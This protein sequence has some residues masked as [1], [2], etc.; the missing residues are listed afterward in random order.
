MTRPLCYILSAKYCH[1]WNM[2][3]LRDAR[4]AVTLPCI[5]LVCHTS[6]PTVTSRTNSMEEQRAMV[7]VVCLALTLVYCCLDEADRPGYHRGGSWRLTS[8][9]NDFSNLQTCRVCSGLKVL[10]VGL[11]W[12]LKAIVSQQS[13]LMFGT[14]E[15][16]FALFLKHALSG[17]TKIAI[18]L[19]DSF[20]NKIVNNHRKTS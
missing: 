17:T 16:S 4:D 9:I 11:G 3:T 19:R 15:F 12:Q 6:T 7:M 20:I 2:V 1:L 8:Y 14:K 10:F 18:I 13:D 5:L